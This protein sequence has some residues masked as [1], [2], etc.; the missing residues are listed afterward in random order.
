VE[1]RLLGPLEVVDD[2]GR[3]MPLTNGRQRELRAFLL[4]RPNEPV[5]SDHVRLRVK[6]VT[7]ASDA[8]HNRKTTR[9]NV[10]IRAPKRS[11]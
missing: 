5:A 4:L 6:A 7:V 1:F 3:A 2:T 9:V 11:R 10:T 8:A